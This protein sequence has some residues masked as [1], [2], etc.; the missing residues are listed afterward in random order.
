MRTI[1]SARALLIDP[2]GRVLLMRLA[3]GHVVLPGQ[4]A[5]ARPTFW[6]TPGGSLDP[7]ESFEDA[8][9]REIREE[10]GLR[11]TQPGC[12]VWTG[13]KEIMR[14]GA[15]VHTVAHV[16]AQR[17]AAFEPEPSGLT[18]EESESFRGFRWW[19]A[20][21]IAASGDRFVPKRLAQLLPTLLD[22]PWP[23]T[24]IPIEV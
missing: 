17:V 2:R 14:D 20:G 7:G 19:S 22:K 16:Y 18:A 15:R 12:W 13:E 21:E 24:P 1:A 3:A 6:V 8:L 23:T 4:R 5:A 9:R 10:T 11:L